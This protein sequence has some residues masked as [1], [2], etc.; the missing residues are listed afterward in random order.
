MPLHAIFQ[1]YN[2][3]CTVFKSSALVCSKEKPLITLQQNSSN[4]LHNITG[5]YVTMAGTSNT[6]GTKSRKK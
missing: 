2:L 6:K 1:A 5:C 3:A 4:Q